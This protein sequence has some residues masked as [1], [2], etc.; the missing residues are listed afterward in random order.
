MNFDTVTIKE[1]LKTNLGLDA[2]TSKIVIIGFGVTGLSVACYLSRLGFDFEIADSRENPPNL[3]S[4]I[5]KLAKFPVVAGAFSPKQFI[6][7]THLIV[8]PGI[9]LTEEVMECEL[10]EILIYSPAQPIRQ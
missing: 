1:C 6:H 8:S 7:A 2:V 5:N 3:N 10:S 4:E 9:S